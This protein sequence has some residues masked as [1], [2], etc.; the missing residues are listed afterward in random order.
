MAYKNITDGYMEWPN[1]AN[2]FIRVMRWSDD[3]PVETHKHEFIEIAFIAYGSCVHTYHSTEVMLIPGDVF[4]ITPHEEHAYGINAKTVIYNC[5]FY[6]E[7]LGEDWNKLQSIKSIFDLLMVEPFYRMESGRQEILH[8]E[9]SEAAAVES[10][11][12]KML[13]E[14]EKKFCDFELMQKSNLISLLC[15]LGRVWEKQFSENK[16]LYGGKRDLLA[17][18]LRFIENNADSELKVEEIAARAYLSPNYFRKVFKDA[19]GMTPIE[20]INK[21]RISKAC[22]LLRD[23]NTTISQVAEIVGMND[24]NYFSRLFKSVTGCTPSEFKRKSE[25]Y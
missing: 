5:L 16:I 4:V 23:G 20:Y 14:Q 18:A 12:K 13:E 10:L 6:P 24:L 25:L 19:I 11:L 8:L 2:N 22:K 3:K 7:A 15:L 9:P 1:A 21:I 17:E